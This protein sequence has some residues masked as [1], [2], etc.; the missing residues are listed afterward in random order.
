M[1][2]DK[3]IRN[4]VVGVW[5]IIALACAAEIAL[6]GNPIFWGVHAGLTAASAF[7]IGRILVEAPALAHSVSAGGKTE[8]TSKCSNAAFIRVPSPR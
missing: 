6:G 7:H 5:L 1:A 3:L 2:R 4:I 8:R